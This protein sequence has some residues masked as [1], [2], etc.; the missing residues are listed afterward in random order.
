[1]LTG[2]IWA[3]IVPFGVDAG[4]LPKPEWKSGDHRVELSLVSR[5]RAEIWDAHATNSDTF[6]A[7][8][9]RGA[10]KYAFKERFSAFVELQDVRINGLGSD[11]SGA[12]ALYRANAAG[13][14]KTSAQRIR[15]LWTEVRP[16]DGLTV[17]IGRQDINLGTELM[18]PE[19]NWKYL[20]VARGSQRV[21]GTVGW[22]EGERSND[23]VTLGYDFGDQYLYLFVVKPTTGVFDINS[24]YASQGDILYGG[25]SWTVKRGAWIPDTEVRFYGIYYED[26]RDAADGAFGGLNDQTLRVWSAGFSSMGIYPCGEGYADLTLAAAYQWGN[27]PAA[28]SDQNHRA[29][30]GILEAGYQ[31]TKVRMKPWFRAGVNLASGDGSATDGDHESFFNVL[32][33]NHLY[34]GF[35]DQY[36]LGN[37]IDYFAQLKLNPIPKMGVNVFLHQFTMMT[38]DDGRHFGTGAFNKNSFGYGLQPSGGHRGMGTELDAVLSYKLNRRVDLQAGYAYMW[39]HALFNDLA[40]DDVRFAYF[41]VTVKY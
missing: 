4:D 36:A 37:L 24:S 14:S 25:L 39:G 33:T 29:W 13:K 32:P 7:F 19:G 17:R 28:G 6:Y 2:V 26:S 34:Y 3:L 30:A 1:M 23:G 10:A 31:F 21:V 38:D 5:F 16:F 27:W 8:R 22:T 9:T 11:A 41:Q 40:D 20:K 12:G 15:Q 18:Y 35:A